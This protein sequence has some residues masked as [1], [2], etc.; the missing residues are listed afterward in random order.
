[1]RRILRWALVAAG[2]ALVAGLYINDQWINP[3]TYE[4]VEVAIH[5][6][7]LPDGSMHIREER[8]VRFAGEFS[9]YSLNFP[10]RGFTAMTD[11]KV[12]EPGKAYTLTKAA[13]SR[14]DGTYTVGVPAAGKGEYKIEWYFRAKGET[15]KFFVEYRVTDCVTV[16]QDVAE[17]YW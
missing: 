7:V 4:N 14:P 10:V 15:R 3:K 2:L 13:D 8:T 9:R 17:L 12:S 1:M 16:Y 6:R 5:A 11:V